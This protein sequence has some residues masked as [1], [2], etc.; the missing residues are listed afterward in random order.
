MGSNERCRSVI[1][2]YF[3]GTHSDTNTNRTLFTAQHLITSRSRVTLP[4]I[5]RQFQFSFFLQIQEFAL[6]NF[7]D[8]CAIFLMSFNNLIKTFYCTTESFD[9]RDK[10]SVLVTSPGSP[11]FNF[12]QKLQAPAH[13]K[14]PIGRYQGRFSQSSSIDPNIGGRMQIKLGFESSALQLILTIVCA[15]DLT[16]RPNGAARNPYAKVS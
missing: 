15:A 10:P 16:Y 6:W 4:K 5:N 7:D 8:N 1:V 12:Q 14:R 2:L 3:Q 11:D 9:G 13:S